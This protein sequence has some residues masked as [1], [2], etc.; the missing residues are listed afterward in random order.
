MTEKEEAEKLQEDFLRHIKK[1]DF[2]DP[3]HIEYYANFFA[4]KV[5]DIIIGELPMETYT[6]KRWKIIME[7]IS[8]LHYNKK[9]RT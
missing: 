1:I 3:V 2:N 4:W 5:A 8:K 7:E 9:C 6:Y